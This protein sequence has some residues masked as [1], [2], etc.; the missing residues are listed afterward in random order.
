MTWVHL[1]IAIVCEVGWAIAMKLSNGFTRLWPAVATVVLYL[2]SVLFLAFATKKM[3]V[4]VGYAIW[5]GS[6]VALIAVA[7]I[8]YFKEP[9]NA[10]KVVS[11]GL[12]V[13]GIAGLQFSTASR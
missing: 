12:I 6:G 8:I 4:G 11:I 5:A 7:G 3:D 2:L 1:S 13:L 9:L 10:L